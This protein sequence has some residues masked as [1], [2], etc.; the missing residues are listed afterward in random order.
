MGM[1]LITAI[2]STPS[3]IP[4]F[5]PFFPANSIPYI[6]L[7]MGSMTEPKYK[8]IERLHLINVQLFTKVVIVLWRARTITQSMI[9]TLTAASE[10]SKHISDGLPVVSH[11]WQQILRLFG[12]YVRMYV[13]DF[14]PRNLSMSRIVK[15]TW[16]CC[17]LLS[18]MSD[19]LS[20]P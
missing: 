12:W 17:A 7:S 8:C 2:G 4:F 3:S 20:Q 18:K 6:L 13:L 11:E 1:D 5:H 10:A 16:L 9:G 19:K 14:E 15:N